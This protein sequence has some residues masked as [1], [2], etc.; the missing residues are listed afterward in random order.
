MSEEWRDIQ[1]YE[2][3]YQVSNLGNIK[4]LFRYKKILKKSPVSSGYLSVELWKDKKNRRH[5]IHRL[6]AKA[7]IPNPEQLPQINHKDEDK[8]NN[9][10]DNLEWCTAKYNMNYGTGNSRRR[11][12]TDYK[13][14]PHELRVKWATENSK[15]RWKPVLQKENGIV[16]AR[17][18]NMYMAERA[19]NPNHKP[20]GNISMVC[21]G[22]R[23]SAYGFQWEYAKE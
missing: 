2:G 23:K 15:F 4:S 18:E 11:E 14:I 16:I 17:Y 6:V 8:T 1:G 19:V 20:N 9:Q 10:V 12:N 3:L 5:L 7:F 21:R 22:K 13:A